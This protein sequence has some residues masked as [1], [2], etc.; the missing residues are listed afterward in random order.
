VDL[1]DKQH[2]N[3][4]EIPGGVG[5]K[6]ISEEQLLNELADESDVKIYEADEFLATIHVPGTYS[7]PKVQLDPALDALI[8]KPLPA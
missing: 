5:Y 1:K 6:N 4:S 2:L 7:L 3:V 8:A